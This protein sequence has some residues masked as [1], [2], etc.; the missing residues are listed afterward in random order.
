MQPGTVEFSLRLSDDNAP[1]PVGPRRGGVGAEQAQRSR[2]NVAAAD[3]QL[4]IHVPRVSPCRQ[5]SVAPTVSVIVPAFDEERCIAETPD[6]LRAAG[7][8]LRAHTD[9]PVQILLVDNASTDRTA[10]IAR[11]RDVTVIGEAEHNIAKVGNAGARAAEHDV[12]VFADAD[13][14]VP[15]QSLLRIGRG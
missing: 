7:E 13:T 4:V 1:P 10:A 6:H 14:L 8:L 9:T 3:H 15:S 5:D 2:I 12:L 11:D